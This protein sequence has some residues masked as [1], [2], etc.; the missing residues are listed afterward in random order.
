VPLDLPTEEIDADSLGR[1]IL[2]LVARAQAGGIDAEQA[3][4][5]AVRDL[6]S[7]VRSAETAAT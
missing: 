7:D 4:R 3:V 2:A 6:E 1:Q 5:E